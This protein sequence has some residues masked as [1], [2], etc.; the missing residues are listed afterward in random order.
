MFLVMWRYTPISPN[1]NA[2]LL[3][4]KLPPKVILTLRKICVLLRNISIKAV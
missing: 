2:I 1:N 4:A 3:N